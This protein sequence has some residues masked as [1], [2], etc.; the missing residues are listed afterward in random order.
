MKRCECFAYHNIPSQKMSLH[1]ECTK[2]TNVCI[3][4]ITIALHVKNLIN[5][6][7]KLKEL[8]FLNMK[9]FND[10]SIFF[11]H[12]FYYFSFL[13]FTQATIPVNEYF[14][15][16]TIASQ[17]DKCINDMTTQDVIS[18]IESLKKFNLFFKLKQSRERKK[19]MG[20]ISLVQTDR[21]IVITISKEE[22]N[23]YVELFL[24]D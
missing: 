24:I 23:W 16:K 14:I 1:S 12:F 21:K 22:I 13:D 4:Q 10:Q 8:R 6:K 18:R 9:L 11:I 20:L 7:K 19:I 2:K 5:I 15:L 3:L 17:F